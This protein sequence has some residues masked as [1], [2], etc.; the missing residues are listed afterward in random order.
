MLT[1]IRLQNMIKKT[2]TERMFL[3]RVRGILTHET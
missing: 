1:V 3:L 2:L